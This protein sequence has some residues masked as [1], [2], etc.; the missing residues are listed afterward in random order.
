[1]ELTD[2]YEFHTVNGVDCIV[3]RWQK[4][5][6]LSKSDKTKRTKKKENTGKDNRDKPMLD[7]RFYNDKLEFCDIVISLSD[8]ATFRRA[9]RYHFNICDE[10]KRINGSYRYEF[11]MK[12][13]TIGYVTIYGKSQKCLIQPY[14]NKEE[15]LLQMLKELPKIFRLQETLKDSL[16]LEHE[17][18]NNLDTLMSTSQD[19]SLQSADSMATETK[20]DSPDVPE[21]PDVSDVPSDVPSTSAI[22]PTKENSSQ[23]ESKHTRSIESQSD[24]I[25]LNHVLCYVKNGMNMGVPNLIKKSVLGFFSEKEILAAKEIL[26]ERCATSI[27]G[28]FKRRITTS[29]RTETAANLDDILDALKLLDRNPSCPIFAVSSLDLNRL[30]RSRPEELNDITVVDRISQ[31]E[32]SFDALKCLF[33]T[34]RC[35]CSC[36]SSSSSSSSSAVRGK[37]AA[38]AAA[39]APPSPNS[40]PSDDTRTSQKQKRPVVAAAAAAAANPPSPNSVP[41]VDKSSSSSS[42]TPGT[43]VRRSSSSSSSATGNSQAVDKSRSSYSEVVRRNVPASPSHTDNDNDINNDNDGFKVVKNKNK[44]STTPDGHNRQDNNKAKKKKYVAVTGINQ[45]AKVKAAPEP[46]RSV[47]LHRLH[48]DTETD[49]LRDMISVNFEIR[50]LVL[51]SQENSSFKSYRLDIPISQFK[52]AFNADMWPQGVGVKPYFWAKKK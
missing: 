12:S 51:L 9:L 6:S 40:A 38:P 17:D 25:I 37:G 2:D 33:E 44:M 29:T 42:L 26:F 21:V 28:V 34:S 4:T 3:W 30:P 27:I 48:K 1:M 20:C 41:S 43:S 47:L 18:G 13:V 46:S 15:Y 32:N 52:N 23:Y 24:S 14:D 8:L 31:L 50:Q 11:N 19:T 39:A 7:M 49:E 22:H 36:S 10:P 35:S 16:L 5:D 45:H